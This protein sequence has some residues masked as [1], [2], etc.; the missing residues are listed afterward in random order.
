MLAPHRRRTQPGN[1][2]RNPGVL[3]DV[4]ANEIALAEGLAGRLARLVLQRCSATAGLVPLPGV[5]VQSGVEHVVAV[6]A[7]HQP[8]VIAGQDRACTPRGPEDL[9]HAVGLDA[10]RQV[11]HI[12][13]M[14]VGLGGVHLQRPFHDAAAE[15]RL[16]RRTLRD[17]H[18]GIDRVVVVVQRIARGQMLLRVAHGNEGQ[19]QGHVVRRRFWP[20]GRVGREAG[21]TAQ[22]HHAQPQRPPSGGPQ[23][24]ADSLHRVTLS[25]GLVGRA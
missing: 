4:Q 9:G 12:A 19:G 24:P 15:Q 21:A 20:R 13:Q 25:K 22:D 23:Q 5:G 17:L 10:A 2:T 7:K 14:Q 6:D 11:H 1:L 16:L 18:V 8:I 3:S